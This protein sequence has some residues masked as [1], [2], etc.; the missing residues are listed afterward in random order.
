MSMPVT[1]PRQRSPWWA[2]LLAASFLITFA[3]GIYGSCMGPAPIGGAMSDASEG[4][5]LVERV[6][7]GMPLENAGVRAGDVVVAVDGQAIR[8]DHDFGEMAWQFEPG[9]PFV[10]SVDRA[11]QQMQ[12]TMLLPERRQWQMRDRRQWLDYSLS[13][14]ARAA[15]S[16][17]GAGGVVRPAARPGRG[18]GRRLAVHVRRFAGTGGW[19][20]DR[21]PVPAVALPAASAGVHVCY[22]VRRLSG[23]GLLRALS[24]PGV[25]APLDPTRAA[26]ARA[27]DHPV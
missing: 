21:R 22:T 24:A 1:T 27:S 2:W 6:S 26:C 10:L 25:P 15:L 12:F 9:K 4:G 18:R 3:V 16:G 23:S 17:D 8:T 13:A 7:P 14:A 5:A 19:R 11:G 20:W